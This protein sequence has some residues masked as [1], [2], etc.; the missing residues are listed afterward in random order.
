[1]AYGTSEHWE[2][3]SS[4]G[5]MAGAVPSHQSP[6][7]IYASP[8]VQQPAAFHSQRNGL[9]AAANVIDSHD[10]HDKYPE[11]SDLLD[12]A[13][14]QQSA[15]EAIASAGQQNCLRTGDFIPLP[16]YVYEQYNSVQCKAFMGLF[17]EI[18][19]VWITMDSRLYLWN[20]QHPGKTPTT[21]FDDQEQIITSVGLVR[22]LPGVFLEQIDYIL[23]VA[24]RLEL[25][26]LGIAFEIKGD[27]STQLT[28]YQTHL[29]VPSDN[30][31][32]VQIDGT[33]EGRIFLRTLSGKLMELRY[34]ASEGWLSHKIQLVNH[35][36]TNFSFITP[37]FLQNYTMEPPIYLMAVDR[38]RKRIYTLTETNDL[39]VIL[40]GEDGKSFR[41]Q[42]KLSDVV[43]R[44]L[45][46]SSRHDDYVRIQ[47]LYPVSSAE[48]SL[49]VLVAITSHGDRIFFRRNG[50]GPSSDDGIDLAYTSSPVQRIVGPELSV[51]ECLYT[52]GLLL[53]AQALTQET[54]RIYSISLN[55]GAVA[56]QPAK[57]WIDA[58]SYHDE[59]G[60]VWQI[61]EVRRSQ[62]TLAAQLA[63]R[64]EPGSVF[65]ELATQLVTSPREFLL[66]TNQG[67]WGLRKLRPID[68]LCELMAAAPEQRS[69]GI[70]EFAHTYG[71]AEACAMCL[72]IACRHPATDTAFREYAGTN[73]AQLT[74]AATRL[75]D[76]F[77]GRPFVQH[78]QAPPDTN[79]SLLGTAVITS[80]VKFSGRHDG[81]ALYLCRILKPVWRNYVVVTKNKRVVSNF[82]P[83]TLSTI[84]TALR[85]LEDFL[86]QRPTFTNLPTPDNRPSAD[87]EAWRAEQESLHNLHDLLRMS[88]E[89]IA[90]LLM[91]V[92]QDISAVFN[93]MRPEQQELILDMKFQNA[94]TEEGG[95][96]V[97]RALMISYIDIKIRDEQNMDAIGEELQSVCPSICRQNDVILFKG[98]EC[99]QSARNQPAGAEQA[100]NIQEALSLFYQVMPHIQFD[101]LTEI[102]E[103]LKDMENYEG[104]VDLVLLW[105]KAQGY[106]E[107]V[108]DPRSSS[109]YGYQGGHQDSYQVNSLSQRQTA[110]RI[111]FSIIE[112]LEA[113]SQSVSSFAQDQLLTLRVHIVRKALARDDQLFHEEFYTWLIEKSRV[114]DLLTLD[115]QYLEDFLKQSSHLPERVQLLAQFYVKNERYSEAAYVY[116]NQA[117]APNLDFDTRIEYLKL[118]VVQARTSLS[119][120]RNV[121]RQGLEQILEEAEIAEVQ[122]ALIGALSS[123]YERLGVTPEMFENLKSSFLSIN[124]LYNAYAKPCKLYEVQLQVLFVSET[125]HV[126]SHAEK[127]WTELIRKTREDAINSHGDVFAALRQKVRDVGRKF[128]TDDNVFPVSFLIN[129]LEQETYEA[130]Q[131]NQPV[132]ESGWVVK[133]LRS[134]DCPFPVMFRAYNDIFEAKLAP[135]SSARALTFLLEDVAVLITE[136]L[137]DRKNPDGSADVPVQVLDDAIQKYLVTVHD[138]DARELV[139]KLQMLAHRIREL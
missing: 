123:H 111:V 100:Q 139:G 86:A 62:T 113:L 38:A 115:T 23:V 1:M 21:C 136:W 132:P 138:G 29:S 12:R 41:R 119:A 5:G 46:G 104:A 24:T 89:T 129:R 87:G 117:A 71:S 81:L 13:Q 105:A 134:V 32:F 17:P 33:E 73:N 37:T 2:R 49:I 64:V 99:I 16:D 26:I 28:F 55:A 79:G 65:N 83:D 11:L 15:D 77:G 9:K 60:K 75:F 120:Q 47:G 27:P 67:I 31:H 114:E 4:W 92:E 93:T 50:S 98:I 57:M 121:D 133:T 112:S 66:L 127:I 45:S 68:L 48:S 19:R 34:S 137:R 130:K 3:A 95:L 101:K 124:D 80:E 110:Y 116:R 96:E 56:Q 84:L 135:W 85:S 90:F 70:E 91:V 94:I 126:R 108:P 88:T 30:E 54:D 36:T 128:H 14:D 53:A 107:G 8:P 76:E 72:A 97:T 103:Q 39:Q 7:H 106:S 58:Y 44:A 63:G 52:D 102:A 125:S 22:P 78:A 82:E 10:N 61:S 6:S 131:Q 118:A 74:S 42:N 122:R 25:I 69:G 35:S 43:G 20:F 59:E 109:A 51:H 18:E 40:L